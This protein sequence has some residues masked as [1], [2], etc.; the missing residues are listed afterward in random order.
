MKFSIKKILVYMLAFTLLS[1][2]TGCDKGSNNG[3]I[4]KWAVTSYKFNDEIYTKEEMSE[5][6]GSTFNEAYGNTTIIFEQD[7]AFSST[8]ASGETQY[9]TYK[10]SDS[11]ISLNDESGNLITTMTFSN[12]TIELAVPNINVEMSVIY[13]KQ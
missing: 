1:A 10:V 3:I 9:G 6:M 12:D 11:E 13:E 4:G 8:P 5:M 2:L 7:N